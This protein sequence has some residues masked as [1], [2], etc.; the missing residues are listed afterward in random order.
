MT[1]ALIVC[2]FLL[3]SVVVGH[4]WA[5]TTLRRIM[6]S[7]SRDHAHFFRTVLILVLLV[8]IHLV[9]ILWF[10]GALYVSR[11]MLAIGDFT[12]KFNPGFQDYFY[13]SIV[14][15]TTLGLSDF[16]PVGH[17]KLITGF[18]ALIGFVMLTWS[19][20]FFYSIS[21]HD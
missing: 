20:T 3:V 14:T 1:I 7:R 4:F 11:E 13:Y 12:N 6:P 5:L 9:E 2:F 16:S 18:E 15:Y 17:M 19:A 21:H 8:C 10:T